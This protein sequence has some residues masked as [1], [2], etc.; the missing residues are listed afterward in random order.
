MP[1]YMCDGLS[2]NLLA[3]KYKVIQVHCLDH[4]RRQFLDL[5]SSFPSE[6][7]YILEKL[8]QVYYADRKAKQLQLNPTDRMKYHQKHSAK[9]KEELG[10]WMMKG[11]ASGDIEKNGPLGGAVNYMLK[12]W[13]EL[14]EFMHTPGVP[15]S[16]AECERTI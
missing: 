15:V 11:L 8:G 13:T 10:H 2:A 9:V 14:N 12:R 4:A 1:I 7:A 3:E 5:Q 16:N 6:T